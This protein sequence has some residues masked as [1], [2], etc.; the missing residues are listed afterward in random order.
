MDY[1]AICFARYFEK[2]TVCREHWC[3][4]GTNH[5]VVIAV[6]SDGKWGAWKSGGMR[7]CDHKSC[8]TYKEDDKEATPINRATEQWFSAE[9]ARY[10]L[11][12]EA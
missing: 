10:R 7:T 11:Y 8:T 5:I 1:F 6:L 2:P 9:E 4:N 12:I 3:V